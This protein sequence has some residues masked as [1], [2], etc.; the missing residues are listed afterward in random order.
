MWR[1]TIRTCAIPVIAALVVVMCVFATPLAQAVNTKKMQDQLKLASARIEKSRES[2]GNALKSYQKAAGELRETEQKINTTKTMVKDLDE[3]IKDKQVL[4]DR[5]VDFLYRTQGVGYLEMIFSANSVSEFAD[6]LEWLGYVSSNDARLVTSLKQETTR[7]QQ[8]L[9]QLSMLQAIQEKTAAALRGDVAQAQKLLDKEQAQADA[10]NSA[11]GEALERKQRAANEREAARK[12]PAAPSVPKKRK[13]QNGDGDYVGTGMTF[14]GIA[15]WYGRGSGTAS[16]ERF[17]PNALTAAHKT[18]PF[19]TY[20]RVNYKGKSVVVRIND[21]GPY[22]KGRVI[23]ISVAAAEI[24]G[25][26]RAGLGQV[27]CEVV[28]KQ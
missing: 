7:H 15:S 3:Q 13:S 28:T 22:S 16:G 5:H 12:K 17:N 14:S 24:I 8:A 9:D 6:S 25:M 1:T 18:L 19:G 23:D 4:L 20:V 10:L 26:K 2:L 27:T 11:I 21:R